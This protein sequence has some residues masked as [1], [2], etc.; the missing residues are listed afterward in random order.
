[1]CCVTWYKDKVFSINQLISCNLC[2]LCLLKLNVDLVLECHSS[3][4]D[5]SPSLLRALVNLIQSRSHQEC[6]SDTYKMG[7]F[8]KKAVL[9]VFLSLT[10]LNLCVNSITRTFKIHIRRR[11]GTQRKSRVEAKYSPGSGSLKDG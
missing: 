2:Y 4:A 6:S 5:D 9:Y 7:P 10:N 3:I 8:K 1:M 11:P